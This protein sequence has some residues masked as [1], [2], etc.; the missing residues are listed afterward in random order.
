MLPHK[1]EIVMWPHIT[2]TSLHPMYSGSSTPECLHS[3]KKATSMHSI[4]LLYIQLIAYFWAIGLNQKALT[5]GRTDLINILA[6]R[7][8][9][10]GCYLFIVS[11]SGLHFSWGLFF[12]HGQRCRNWFSH[13]HFCFSLS[14]PHFFILWPGTLIYELWP[15]NSTVH[16]LD[17]QPCHMPYS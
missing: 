5:R 4:E 6:E 1:I 17:E 7:E 2:V 10:A 8:L 3:G 11:N 16:D 14:R 9:S 13:L 15:S 12:S